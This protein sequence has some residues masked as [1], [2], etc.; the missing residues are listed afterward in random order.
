MR[1]DQNLQQV[2]EF[3]SATRG[4]Q[5]DLWMNRPTKD[6]LNIT[7]SI[8]YMRPVPKISSKVARAALRRAIINAI[9]SSSSPPPMQPIGWAACLSPLGSPLGKEHKCV[10]SIYGKSIRLSHQF[11]ANR[12]NWQF[13]FHAIERLNLLTYSLHTS[14]LRFICAIYK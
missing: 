7:S 6:W 10:W 11:N 1:K 2:G 14:N 8:I 12:S 3:L 9:T 5:L 4:T 13:D